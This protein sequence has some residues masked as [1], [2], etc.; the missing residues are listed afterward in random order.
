M[1]M[2][3]EKLKDRLEKAFYEAEMARTRN[4]QVK[5]KDVLIVLLASFA[6]I[7]LGLLI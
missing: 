7:C 3:L 5:G 1:A 6:L 2:A 4:H